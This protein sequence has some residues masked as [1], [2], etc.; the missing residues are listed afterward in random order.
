MFHEAFWE[1]VSKVHSLSAISDLFVFI[2]SF[3]GV[4][5]QKM[6]FLVGVPFRSIGFFLHSVVISWSFFHINLPLRPFNV[7]WWCFYFVF[8]SLYGH[9]GPYGLFCGLGPWNMCV[10]LFHVSVVVRTWAKL[11]ETPLG[12]EPFKILL[13]F[14]MCM[15][16]A[17]WLH[18]TPCKVFIFATCKTSNTS[19]R[20]PSADVYPQQA[21]VIK[22]CHVG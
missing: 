12:C 10:L 4:I 16:L 19:A 2:G 15:C 21:L 5:D 11:C 22:L 13:S 6:S 14:H 9:N 1:F 7:S 3:T 20:G 17:T 18:S 8:L